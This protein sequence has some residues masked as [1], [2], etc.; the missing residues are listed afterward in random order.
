MVLSLKV[1]GLVSCLVGLFGAGV[2]ALVLLMGTVGGSLLL[3][4]S[5]GV[6]VSGE[7]VSI[8]GFWF[9]DD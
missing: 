9:C 4:F 8:I 1:I 5:V 7:K 6:C 2:S 3:L